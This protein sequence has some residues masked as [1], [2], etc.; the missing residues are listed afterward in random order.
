M[1]IIGAH[2]STSGGFDQALKRAE[3]LGANGMQIFSGSPR[4]WGRGDLSKIDLK[5]WQE[6][7]RQTGIK[8]VVIHALYLINLASPKDSLVQ[9][10]IKALIYDLKL[11]ALLKTDGVIVHLGSHLGAGW[12]K[13]KP[14]LVSALKQILAATPA[15]SQLLIENSAGQKGKIGSDLAEIKELLEV[16][17][18]PRLGWC[19]DTCHAWAAGYRLN[20]ELR[21]LKPEVRSQKPKVEKNL[22]SEINQLDLWSSL[23]CIHVND[24]HGQFDSGLDR[25]ENLGQGTIPTVEFKAFLNFAKIKKLPLIL[26]VPGLKE[27]TLAKSNVDQLKHLVS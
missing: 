17:S 5:L 24:S 14:Q 13:V 26:E 23:K 7:K 16:V 1:T 27:L 9:S 4:G 10:S 3:A 22:I 8:A 21:I 25:H 18:S 11:D 19:V 2:V 12:A 20:S 6:T 15:D